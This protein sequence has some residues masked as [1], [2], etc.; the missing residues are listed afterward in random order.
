LFVPPDV[1]PPQAVSDNPA[2][3]NTIR[4]NIAGNWMEMIK[5]PIGI[6]GC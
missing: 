5:L 4:R 6:L 3:T 2:A 1:P